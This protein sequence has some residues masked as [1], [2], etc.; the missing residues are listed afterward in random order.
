MRQGLL[1]LELAREEMRVLL[2]G[3]PQLLRFLEPLVLRFRDAADTIVLTPAAT[4]L[5]CLCRL[6]LMSAKRFHPSSVGTHWS[7]GD[8]QSLPMKGILQV[9]SRK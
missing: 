8:R 6:A 9:R 5:N 2:G 4:L 7:P 1:A 3:L